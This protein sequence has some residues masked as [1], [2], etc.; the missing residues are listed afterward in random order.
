MK[1]IFTY[2]YYVVLTLQ[3]QFILLL[4]SVHVAV[5]ESAKYQRC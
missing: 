5:T 4:H 2:P 3:P 1:K